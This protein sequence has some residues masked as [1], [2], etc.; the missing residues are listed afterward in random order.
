[1]A[2]AI[3]S[4]PPSQLGQHALIYSSPQRAETDIRQPKTNKA[5]VVPGP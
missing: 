2:S 3:R 5:P 4:M 1:L